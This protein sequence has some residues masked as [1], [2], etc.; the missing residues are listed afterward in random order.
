MSLV[1]A[2]MPARSQTLA[3]V[4]LIVVTGDKGEFISPRLMR[5]LMVATINP[6]V[7]IAKT[8]RSSMERL[9]CSLRV[10]LVV[11]GDLSIDRGISITTRTAYDFQ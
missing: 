10:P 3:I 2:R 5:Y 9:N 8:D 6:D 7:E 11:L 4:T 1:L